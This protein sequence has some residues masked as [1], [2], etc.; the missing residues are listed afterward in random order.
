MRSNYKKLG[1]YIRQID[2]RNVEGKK[3]NLLG[4]STQK[5]FI[6]SIANTVG[7]DFTKYKIVKKYQFTYVPDTSRRGDKIGLAMLEHIDE[8]LVSQAYTVFEIIDKNELDPEYLMMWFRRPEFDRYARYKSH[9]SVREIFG[10]DEMCDVELPMPSIEKQREIVKEYNTIV[11]RIKLNDQLNQKL[12]ETA[13]AIYKQWFVD[14]E[15]PISEEY[16]NS[17]NRPDLTGKPY[18]SNGGEMV[19][20]EE[21]EQEIPVKWVDG[22]LSDLVDIVN[23]Y[24]FKSDDFS[25]EGNIPVI[26][27]KNIVP[28][29]IELDDAEYFNGNIDSK[30]EKY[31]VKPG[32]I[33]VSMT[34]SHMQQINSAVGKVG[35]YNHQ[36]LSLLNQRVAKLKQKNNQKYDEYVY[37]FITDKNTHMKLLLSSTGSANQANISPDQIL[38]LELVIPPYNIVR[39]FEYISG[40]LTKKNILNEQMKRSFLLK[41]ESLILSRMASKQLEA[42]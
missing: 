15:F 25:E 14:F 23:G 35:R 10:W 30:I 40:V 37:Y 3:E 8:G 9:G 33:L 5:V 24:A 17:I 42:V 31:C 27:I 34:G 7:T 39:S 18:K 2:I 6:E 20:N 11:N 28:P 21:L 41:M 32:D 19:Y 29:Y 4:V 38:N 13:Q 16:A 36:N 12:E 26:K 22:K 1:P